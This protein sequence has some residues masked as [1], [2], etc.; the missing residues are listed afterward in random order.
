MREVT[1]ILISDVGKR[2]ITWVCHSMGGLLVKKILVEEWKN[3]DKHNICK[4]TRSIIFYST[5]HRGSHIAAL[6]QTTQMFI[7]P[8]IEVQE[9]RQESPN[10]LQLHK[11]FL[12]MLNDYPMEIVSFSET[13]S[14]LVT[15]LKL[16]F[17]F[18]TPDSADPGI[19]EFFQIPQDHLTICKPANRRSFLYHKLLCV[20][21]RQ[22]E[23][24]K[25]A[26]KRES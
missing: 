21:R 10:L 1:S 24:C 7:W 13:K 14:T 22:L 16:S 17:Q 20:L 11:D 4:N 15:A 2:P 23:S 18:V 8:S 19:G 26:K 9:L 25:D 5:P 6:T 3:G 12:E